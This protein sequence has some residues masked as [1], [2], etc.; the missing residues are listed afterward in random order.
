MS[1][2]KPARNATDET[3]GKQEETPQQPSRF[4]VFVRLAHLPRK[5]LIVL[6]LLALSALLAVTGTIALV[7]W[8]FRKPAPP[9]A[10][11]PPAQPEVPKRPGRPTI[12][13][14][15]EAI[16]RGDFVGI[17]RYR[18]V[19][20]PPLKPSEDKAEPS[21]P[22]PQAQPAQAAAQPGSKEAANEPLAPTTALPTP[23]PARSEPAQPANVTARKSPLTKQGGCE[24]GTADAKGSAAS[25][26][27]CIRYFNVLEGDPREK[28]K[29]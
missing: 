26:V 23:P 28:P 8:L 12:E 3:T 1:N 10:P 2:A 29:K 18:T 4:A 6:G 13:E 7:A 20:V 25:I 21:T 14:R 15:F 11:P 9:P 19:P 17:P 24:V 5:K 27:D 22:A 16:K